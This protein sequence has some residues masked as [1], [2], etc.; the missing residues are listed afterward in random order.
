MKTVRI[1]KKKLLDK[2]EQNMNDH[3]FIYDEAMKGWKCDVITGLAVSL[4]RAKEGREY[5]TDLELEEPSCHLDE[6]KNI[7]E[8]VNWHEDDYIELDHQEFNQFIL[9]KWIWQYNFLSTSSSYS[10]SS[11]SSASSMIDT[12]MSEL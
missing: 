12:K 7:I 1:S 3:K 5:V 8:R 10:S 6:Y 9:D 2:L 11:S 4:K